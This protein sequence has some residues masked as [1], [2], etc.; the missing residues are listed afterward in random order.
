[1]DCSL[2]DFSVH[3]IFQ[4]RVLE[5]VT[6]SFSRGSSWP[7]SWTRVSRIAGRRFTVWATREAQC[8][9]IDIKKRVRKWSW[10]TL[11]LNWTNSLN[12]NYDLI[13]EKIDNLEKKIL[14]VGFMPCNLKTYLF[15]SFFNGFLKIFYIKD[16]IIHRQFYFFLHSV[17]PLEHQIRCWKADF[18]SF[19]WF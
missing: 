8:D 10:I 9:P 11:C 7:R 14:C 12:R 6:I 5:W 13:Q 16:H 18:L 19:L 4:A 17:A 15:L 1:M 3:G 2:P